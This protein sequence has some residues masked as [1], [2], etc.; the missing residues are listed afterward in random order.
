MD[1]GALGLGRLQLVLLDMHSDAKGLTL[2]SVP[3]VM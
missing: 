1:V 2:L 3:Q